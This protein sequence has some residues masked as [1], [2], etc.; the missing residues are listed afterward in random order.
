MTT[1]PNIM[2]TTCTRCGARFQHNTKKLHVFMDALFRAGW[3]CEGE[4]GHYTCPDCREI[5][6]AAIDDASP[7]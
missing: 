2:A 5:L 6:D 1:T 3:S 4:D 7:D